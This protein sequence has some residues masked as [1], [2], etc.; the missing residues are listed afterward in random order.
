[1]CEQSDDCKNQI[2]PRFEPSHGFWVLGWVRPRVSKVVLLCYLMLV[3]NFSADDDILSVATYFLMTI[4]SWRVNFYRKCFWLF[5][6]LICPLKKK[7]TGNDWSYYGYFVTRCH[8]YLI[9]SSCIFQP[10]SDWYMFSSQFALFWEYGVTV[11]AISLPTNW[12]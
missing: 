5:F 1:M 8:W 11:R 2:N 10:V 12:L 4:L 3:L 6:S 7:S 9:L